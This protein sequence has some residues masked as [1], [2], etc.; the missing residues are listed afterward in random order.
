MIGTRGVPANYG[1]FETA[2]EEV[3]ARLVEAGHDVLVFS[4]SAT[5]SAQTYRG[6]RIVR[7]PAIKAKSL[8]TLSHTALSLVSRE[9]TGTDVA[10]LF[11]AANAPLLPVLRM[12]GIPAAVHV[13][14][15]EWRRSKWGAVGKRYYKAAESLAVRWADVLIADARGIQTYYM[16]RH[17][18]D[19]TYIAY[20]SKLINGPS[21]ERLSAL[22]L[23]PK[24]FILIVA[25]FEPENN[26]VPAIA[27]LCAGE[28]DIPMVVVGSAPYAS[29]Y[30]SAI[31]RL[32]R[33]DPRVRLLGGIWDQELLDS[34]YAGTALYVHGHSVGGTN[35]SLLRAMG[36]RAPV[37]AFDVVYNREV[38]GPENGRFWTSESEL[39]KIVSEV[40]DYPEV[41]NHMA[42]AARDRVE[43]YYNWDQVALAYEQVAA[44]LARSD[45]ASVRSRGDRQP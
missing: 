23:A 37:A 4:R 28:K 24:G 12:R 35:P 38:L 40:V 32:A 1:G 6:M 26:L 18:A 16:D 21:T 5:P 7:R 13:D 43:H 39:S 42:S 19:T 29:K 31:E 3:G 41:A 27:G 30:V 22:G 44:D 20:G 36:A 11:N 25:R 8:E 34:L 33:S 9:L 10:F 17:G 15:V 45:K 14:G 2:V